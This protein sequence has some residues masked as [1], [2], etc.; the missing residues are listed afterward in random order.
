MESWRSFLENEKSDNTIEEMDLKM[1]NP[2]NWF[3]SNPNPTN[4]E[5]EREKHNKG[6]QRPFRNPDLWELYYDMTMSGQNSHVLSLVNNVE[7]EKRKE[8]LIRSID[9]YDQLDIV[10]KEM[11]VEKYPRLGGFAEGEIRELIKRVRNAD[12]GLRTIQKAIDFFE[13]NR[14][15]FITV[16][17]DGD[18]YPNDERSMRRMFSAIERSAKRQLPVYLQELEDALATRLKKDIGPDSLSTISLAGDK[19]MN[20]CGPP[21]LDKHREYAQ[22]AKR[23]PRDNSLKNALALGT[24]R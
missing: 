3:K 23:S 13:T 19:A 22:Q 2:L 11:L 14:N 12:S 24:R 4:Y 5:K 8:A 10:A 9:K 7:D 6:S 1:L 15:D 20:K 18:L 16:Y 21:A 17:R